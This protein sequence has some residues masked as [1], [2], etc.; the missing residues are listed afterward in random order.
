MNVYSW[1]S[2]PVSAFE[3]RVLPNQRTFVGPY[4][5]T[6][7]VLDMLGERWQ[8]T[9]T[10]APTVHDDITGAALEAFFDRLKGQANAVSLWHVRRPRPQG[11]LAGAVT[12]TWTPGTWTPGTWVAG[13]PIVA[14]DIAQLANTGTILTL[15]GR[16]LK[17]G[18]QFSMGG[19]LV[20]QMVNTVADGTGRMPIEFQPRARNVIP[21]ATSIGWDTPTANFILK[22]GTPN[23]PTVW[24]PDMIEGAT[25]EFIEV[26]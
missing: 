2:F 11:T 20:R 4:T 12:A 9:M 18:D 22:P 6:V 1:P 23:V 7:Q 19:Q 13:A 26:F 8:I 5:P 16:T 21:R 24:T 15:P 3:M 10:L 17:A 14:D 25:I